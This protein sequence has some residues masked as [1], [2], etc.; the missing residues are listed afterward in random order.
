[1]NNESAWLIEAAGPVWWTGDS[2]SQY[3]FDRDANKAIRFT[4]QEDAERVR[5][6]LFNETI[7]VLTKTT[8][9]IWF[10][11]EVRDGD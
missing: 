2:L 7:R 10:K 11:N 4:R 1:M 6:H 3:S 9:H 5:N 8:E